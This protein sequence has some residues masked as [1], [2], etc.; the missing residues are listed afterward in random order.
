MDKKKR[1]KHKKRATFTFQRR[2]GTAR[3]VGARGGGL[4][5][6]DDGGRWATVGKGGRQWGRRV[7]ARESEK[8]ERS[9]VL[10]GN[11]NLGLEGKK[12]NPPYFP[13]P[14]LRDCGRGKYLI[15]DPVLQTWVVNNP[16][17]H[18]HKV[19]S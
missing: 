11:W 5:E 9:K 2:D 13:R 17:P 10:E 7:G 3:T 12:I 15:H 4:R 18:F 14:H 16:R 19:W 1:R 6:R 8:R